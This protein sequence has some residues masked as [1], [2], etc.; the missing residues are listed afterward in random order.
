MED[1]VPYGN[2]KRGRFAGGALNKK[3]VVQTITF[4]VDADLQQKIKDGSELFSLNHPKAT[5]SD[6][7]RR[8]I[9]YYITFN[10]D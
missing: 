1:R 9:D 7:I 8:A 3:K 5:Q 2:F 10:Q 6:F 4:S